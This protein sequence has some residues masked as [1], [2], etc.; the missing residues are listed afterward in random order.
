MN[1]TRSMLLLLPVAA[2]GVSLAVVFFLRD[3]TKEAAPTAS[4]TPVEAAVSMDSEP[5]D[6]PTTP[7]LVN[8]IDSIDQ[9]VDLLESQPRI[10]PEGDVVF[11][12][13]YVPE[14]FVPDEGTSLTEDYFGR[15]YTDEDRFL[16]LLVAREPF[17]HLRSE[18]E[19]GHVKEVAV[20]GQPAY[21]VRGDW[22]T[23][24]P[25]EHSAPIET[26]DSEIS[27]SVYM[28]LGDTWF[29]ISMFGAPAE[30]GFD[31]H[32]LLKVAE[33]MEPVDIVKE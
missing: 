4:A 7:L 29:L 23:V 22:M 18:I 1:V 20:N 27:L 24:Y 11:S 26:W 2:V 25:D 10:G 19:Q 13:M 9:I 8:E 5:V 15:L 14:G 32:E 6:P 31:E 21:L 12:P 28:N 17:Y 30:H 3:T 33:S 16:F